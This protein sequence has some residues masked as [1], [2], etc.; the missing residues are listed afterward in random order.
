MK[1]DHPDLVDSWTLARKLLSNF[2]MMQASQSKGQHYARASSRSKILIYAKSTR[3]QCSG[4]W[5]VPHLA[6]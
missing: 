2:V 1:L 4:K 5:A 6:V 3:Y